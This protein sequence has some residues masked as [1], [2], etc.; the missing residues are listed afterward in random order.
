MEIREKKRWGDVPF[1]LLWT[2]VFGLLAHGFAYFNA[3][4]SHDALYQLT[5]DDDLW[6]VSLGRFLQPVWLS[7]IHI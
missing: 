6:Q 3:N 2:F 1:C 4:F 5:A 7:L